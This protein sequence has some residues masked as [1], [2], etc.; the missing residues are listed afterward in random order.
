MPRHFL[1]CFLVS[2]IAF[3]QISAY[4]KPLSLFPDSSKQDEKAK[5][6]LFGRPLAAEICAPDAQK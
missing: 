6:G 3:I 5:Y 4:G 2:S 1:R